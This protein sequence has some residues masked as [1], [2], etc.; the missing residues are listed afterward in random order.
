MAYF[1]D[2]YP[3]WSEYSAG[4]IS[5]SKRDRLLAPYRAKLNAVPK[6]DRPEPP[7]LSAKQLSR[8][9]RYWR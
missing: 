2:I 5:L 8:L 4:K 6:G 3:I 1:T 7:A 9:A